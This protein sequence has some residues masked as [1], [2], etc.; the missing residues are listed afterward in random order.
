MVWALEGTWSRSIRLGSGAATP[1]AGAAEVTLAGAD[2]VAAVG[3]RV[4]GAAGRELVDSGVVAMTWTSGSVTLC[5]S[6]AAGAVTAATPAELNSHL[7]IAP[8]RNER[9]R[10]TPPPHI[11]VHPSIR[12]NYRT[13]GAPPSR[14]VFPN[15]LGNFWQ[16][17]PGDTLGRTR[18]SRA[19]LPGHPPIP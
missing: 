11:L 9:A 17:V 5:A 14:T 2:L 8:R 3:A 7:K 12:T 15:L 16:C 4:A 19:A 13:S 6:T 10:P 1:V 18:R